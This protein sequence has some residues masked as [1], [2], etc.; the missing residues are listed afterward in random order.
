MAAPDHRRIGELLADYG[1]LSGAEISSH[2]EVSPQAI[3]QH[4]KALRE[5]AP[6]RW[7]RRRSCASTVDF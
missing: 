4:L 7:R 1:P 2:F 6:P 5:G 3:S